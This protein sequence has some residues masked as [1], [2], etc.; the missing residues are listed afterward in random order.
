MD[1]LNTDQNE[2]STL[3]QPSIRSYLSANHYLKDYYHYRKNID[4]KFSYDVWAK[5]LGLKSRSGV[6]MVVE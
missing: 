1:N 5:E 2:S 6:R 3:Q 4:G